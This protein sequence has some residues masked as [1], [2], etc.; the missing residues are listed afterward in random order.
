VDDQGRLYVHGDAVNRAERA[1]LLFR[2]VT[3]SRFIRWAEL[4]TPGAP[5]MVRFIKRHLNRRREAMPKFFPRAQVE[6]YAHGW[7][8]RGVRTL[9][10]GHF[11]ETRV[12]ETADGGLCQV[13]PA[14]CGSGLVGVVSAGD[15]RAAVRHWRDLPA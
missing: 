7:Y 1:Y 8:G 11:H 2:A 9:Y 12:C 3:R 10:L 14:W 5:G 13:V 4:V 6:A 15:R